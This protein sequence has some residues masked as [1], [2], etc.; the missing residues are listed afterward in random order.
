MAVSADH[1]V[2]DGET[3]SKFLADVGAAMENP[4]VML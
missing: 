2:V 1:R 4:A 3:I